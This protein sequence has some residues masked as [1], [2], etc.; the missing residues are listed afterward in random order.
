MPI[1]DTTTVFIRRIAR[2][3]SPFVGGRDHTTHHL[4]YLGISDGR[5]A[6]IFAGFSLFS[7]VLVW[8]LHYAMSDWSFWYSVLTITY[9]AL[10]FGGFQV[11]YEKGKKAKALATAKEEQ[12]LNAGNGQMQ[13]DEVAVMAKEKAHL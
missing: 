8:V 7:I 6:A 11:I 10:L 5:V 1:I 3:Q 2:G 9:F 4:A 12:T 13:K